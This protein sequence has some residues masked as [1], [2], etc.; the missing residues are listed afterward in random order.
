MT[1]FKGI[2]FDRGKLP[3]DGAGGVADDRGRQEMKKAPFN[4]KTTSNS[5]ELTK[6]FTS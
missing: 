1:D 4:A 5:L 6:D 2:V 3:I